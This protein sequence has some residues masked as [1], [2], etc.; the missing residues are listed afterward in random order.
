MA[1]TKTEPA[2]TPGNDAGE[3]FLEIQGLSKTFARR[4]RGGEEQLVLDR[5]D[6]TAARREFVTVIGPSGCGK[7]TLLNCIA[8]LTTYDSGRLVADGREV[9]GPGPDRAVVFQHASLLPWRT[10]ERN[11]AYGLELRR[12]LSRS[13]IA[14]R[15]DEALALVGLEGFASHYP[16]E[17]SGGMQQRANLARALAVDPEL[18]LMDEPFGALDAL[19][20]E[21]LQD[22]LS[23]LAARV[24]RTTVFITHDIGEAVFLGDTVHVMSARPGRIDARIEVPFPRPRAREITT[25]PEFEAI[26]TDLRTRLLGN[27]TTDPQEV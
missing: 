21:R 20:K 27:S 7:S 9:H 24:E 5:V 6:L 8:G 10:I 26:V 15:V 4:R 12:E 1:L 23:A 14:E 19:T 13:E 11:V 22:E 2:A 18:M 25:T 16:H 17:V 3:S